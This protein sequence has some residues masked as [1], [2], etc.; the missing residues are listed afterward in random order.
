MPERQA[1][2]H[3]AADGSGAR[4]RGYLLRRFPAYFAASRSTTPLRHLQ[5]HFGVNNAS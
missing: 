5:R 2:L 3:L 4:E 1:W